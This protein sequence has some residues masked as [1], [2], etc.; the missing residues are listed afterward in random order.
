MRKNVASTSTLSLADVSEKVTPYWFA[1]AKPLMVEMSCGTKELDW[2]AIHKFISDKGYSAYT[3]VTA[4]VTFVS[5]QYFYCSCAVVL[6]TSVLTIRK[7][8]IS[9]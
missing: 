2:Y 6:L 3:G 4:D 8:D 5:H 9:I 7:F 1:M